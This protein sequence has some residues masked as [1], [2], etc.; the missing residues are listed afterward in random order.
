MATFY[1][2]VQRRN[3]HKGASADSKLFYAQAKS[4]GTSDLP[5]LCQMI[6]ER[7]TVSSADVKA[8]LDSL[9]YVMKQELSDGR[10]VKLNDFGN[11]R[12]TFGSEG[13]EEEKDFHSSLIRRP[14]YTFTPGKALQDQKKLL[15]YA[16]ITPE[17][18]YLDEP[19]PL[20]HIE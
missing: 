6:S 5:R 19:C 15:Q 9:V 1:K 8:V 17:V 2:L 16:K 13:V 14:K 11:F 4:M 10:I 7:S 20:P 18:I 3:M 12:I